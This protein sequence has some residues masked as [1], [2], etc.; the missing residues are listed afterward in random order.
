MHVAGGTEENDTILNQESLCWG[1]KSQMRGEDFKAF[2]KR[3][4]SIST[5][6]IY[7]IFNDNLK[8]TDYIVSNDLLIS[9]Q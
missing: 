6:F 8:R 2:L 1:H 5:L 4:P 9:E 7:S 3:R